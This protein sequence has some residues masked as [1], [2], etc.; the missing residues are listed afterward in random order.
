[1]EDSEKTKKDKMFDVAMAI[2][3]GTF[4]VKEYYNLTDGGMEAIYAAGHEFF[5]HKK[6]DQAKRIF[7]ILCFLDNK[8]AKFL[9]AYGVTSF[10]LKQYQEAEFAYR[11]ALLAGDYTP[12]L[13]LRIAEA[14][15]A[16]QKIKEATECLREAVL[17]VESDEC[18]DDDS[19]RAAG[20]AAVILEALNSRAEKIEEVQVE[21]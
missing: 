14:C 1:M 16:Q 3:D 11:T 12:N 21:Q 13:F 18:T 19:K 6:Y 8:S 4:D 20:R 10:M 15:L 17:L 5:Q 7:S 9:Y 2:L